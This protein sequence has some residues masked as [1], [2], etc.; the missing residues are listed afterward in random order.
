[1]SIDKAQ[2]SESEKRLSELLHDLRTPLNQIIG[3][4]EMLLEIAEEKGHADLTVGLG[5]VREGGLDLAA[6]LQDRT[7]IALGEQAG[8]EFW[9]LPD[10]SRSSIGRVLGFCELILAEPENSRIGEYL[11]DIV[12]IC[13]AARHLAL[14]VVLASRVQ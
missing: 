1:M 9:S 4:S 7:I 12:L 13:N 5:A 11:E 8:G 3:L 10:A 2:S 14:K 6:M